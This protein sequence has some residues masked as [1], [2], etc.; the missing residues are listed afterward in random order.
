MPNMQNNNSK[1]QLDSNNLKVIEDQ[2]SYEALLTKKYKEYADM[3]TDQ[4]LKNLCTDASN[5]HKQSFTSLKNYLD[6]HQ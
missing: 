4:N 3:C 1:P 6:S 5:T 2:I